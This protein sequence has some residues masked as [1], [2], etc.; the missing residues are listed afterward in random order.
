[1]PPKRECNSD[2]EE[3][4]KTTPKQKKTKTPPSSPSKSKTSWTAEEE[5]KFREGINGIIK[6][7]LWN[8]LKSDPDMVRRG[9]NGVAEHWKAMFKKMQKA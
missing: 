8:E 7:N 9:A 3:D 1:M 2:T 4:V 5:Y 6:K